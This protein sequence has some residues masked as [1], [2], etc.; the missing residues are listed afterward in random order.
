MTNF[1]SVRANGILS[2]TNGGLQGKLSVASGGQLN[3]GGSAGKFLYNF[4]LTNAG[5]VNWSGGGLSVGGNNIL[6]T[7]ITNSACGR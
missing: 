1:G 5:T 2:V 7:T 6:T 3:L 4:A